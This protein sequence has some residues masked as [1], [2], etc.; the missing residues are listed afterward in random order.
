MGRLKSKHRNGRYKK[1]TEKISQ[2]KKF[3]VLTV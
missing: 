3:T 1:E 2:T